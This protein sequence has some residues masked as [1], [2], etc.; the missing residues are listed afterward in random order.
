MNKL[1]RVINKSELKR[2]EICRQANISRTYLF[3]LENRK[4]NP[5]FELIN[6]LST[7]LNKTAQEL[8]F[9]EYEEQ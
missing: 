5:S 1:K 9:E 6:K 7:I 4:R 3:Y 8:F 2:S